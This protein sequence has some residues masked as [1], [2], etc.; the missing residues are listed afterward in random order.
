VDEL[1]YWQGRLIAA[2]NQ[3]SVFDKSNVSPE[4][5]ENFVGKDVA[6]KLLESKPDN[7]GARKLFGEDLQVGG[8]GMKGFYDNILPKSLDKLGK[9]F[10]AK[11]GKTEM[12]GV[13]VWQMDI[14]PQMRETVTKQG[15]PLFQIGVGGGAAAGAA[16]MQDNEERM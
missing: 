16:T 3:R 13:E 12:D 15:Q 11:V 5:L 1:F 4:Q 14:T 9:K 6:K 10:D 2:K 8:E 7:V